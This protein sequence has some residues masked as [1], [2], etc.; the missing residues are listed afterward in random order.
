MNN[1]SLELGGDNWAEKDASLL[2]YTVSDDSGRFYPREFTFARGSNLAATRIGK[3]GLIEKGRENLLLRSNQFDTTW[4]TTN[5]SVTSG[6][7]GYDGSSDAWLLNVTGGTCCQQIAQNISVSGVNTF[8]AYV[9]KG[10]KEGCLIYASGSGNPYADFNLAAGSVINK[11][12]GA[13]DAKIQPVGNDWYRCSVSFTGSI[14]QVRIY[15]ADASGGISQT[16]GNIYIQDAQVEQGLAASPYIPTTTTS[17]QAGVLE[18]TPRL[19]YTAGVANPSL[20]LEPSRTQLLPYTEWIGGWSDV[21]DATIDGVQ[22]FILGST[23]AR[24]QAGSIGSPSGD[25]VFYAVFDSADIGKTIRLAYFDGTASSWNTGSD[26][27]IDSNGRVERLIST[28]SNVIGNVAFYGTSTSQSFTLKYCQLES[29]SYPTSYIPNHSGGTI[30][31]G[32]DD[33]SK[34]G[35][36]DLI[37]QTEGTLFL[38]FIFDSEDGSLDFRFQLSDGASA[39]EWIFIGIANGFLRAYV[40]DA[41]VVQ[42]DTGDVS[43]TIGTRYKI[44]LAYASN[45]FAVYINGT[46]ETTSTSGTIP[47]TNAV[48]LSSAP[49]DTRSVLKQRV[50]QALLFK[51]RLSNADLATL[52]TI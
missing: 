29:G 4:G 31:R 45:D 47:A 37:G 46:Q 52:T 51:E 44:A 21:N 39:S 35:V 10:T 28:G 15:V 24:I 34:T 30:T 25:F 32:A 38:D 18:N 2:G 41:N 5:A 26:I 8:S 11:Y 6:Q 7:S 12:N 16:S 1:A 9:K 48:S 22:S 49:F 13:I 3:T 27:T 33:C 42:F 40:R 36:S 17:A 50:N 14:N 43:A 20:L 19:N 23:S